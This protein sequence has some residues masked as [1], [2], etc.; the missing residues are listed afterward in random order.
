MAFSSILHPT[1]GGI[2]TSSYSVS[3]LQLFPLPRRRERERRFVD[4]LKN[5][6]KRKKKKK[7]VDSF[8][9]QGLDTSVK[10]TT[11]AALYA[12]TKAGFPPA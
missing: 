9:G 2:S 11:K 3:L 12:F 4:L 7:K 1:N 8:G 6:E 5:E 10:T